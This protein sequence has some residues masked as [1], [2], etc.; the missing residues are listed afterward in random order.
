MGEPTASVE[1]EAPANAPAADTG[2]AGQ[3]QDAEG[4]LNVDPKAAAVS[5]RETAAT[6]L[7][8]NAKAAAALLALLADKEGK[9]A[10]AALMATHAK[11]K[12]DADA[13]A[14]ADAKAGA[15]LAKAA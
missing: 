12:A 15:T 8:G 14:A 1:A 2:S 4:G 11:A 6:V 7:M 9:A 13:K 10:L 3:S 5:A